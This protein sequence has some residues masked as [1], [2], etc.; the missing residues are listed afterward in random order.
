[1][2]KLY[3]FLLIMV[4]GSAL[5]QATAYPVDDL[6]SCSGVFD[7]EVQT[8]VTLANQ[9]PAE[10]SVSYFLSEPDA[11]ANVNPIAPGP[12]VSFESPQLIIIR[13]TNLFNDDYGLTAFH[14]YTSAPEVPQFP[15]M[16]ACGS[17]ALEWPGEGIQYFTLPGGQGMELFPGDVLT[18]PQTVYVF[19]EQDGCSSESS[20][21]VMT[22]PLPIIG[23]ITPLYSCVSPPLYNLEVVGQQIQGWNVEQVLITYHY[24]ASD[25]EWGVN[26][27]ESPMAYTALSQSEVIWVR[28]SIGG[29]TANICVSVV[30]VE[31]LSGGCEE[32]E[33]LITG[34]IHI[35]D[36][37]NGCNETSPGLSGAVVTAT[38]GNT[39]HYA[40]TNADGSYAFYGVEP[41]TAEVSINTSWLS[42]FIQPVGPGAQAVTVVAEQTAEA[43]FCVNFEEYHDVSISVYPGV[44]RPGLETYVTLFLTNEGSQSEN[45]VMTYAF[46]DTLLDFVSSSSGATV[47]GNIV[48]IPFTVASQQTIAVVLTFTVATPPVAD[49]GMVLN[50]TATAILD[51]DENQENNTAVASTTIV[52]SYDPND[53]TVHEGA[54]ISEAQAGDYLHYTVRFQNMGTAEALQVRIENELSAFLDWTTF[55]PIAAS[56][57]FFTERQNGTLTFRFP[58]INLAPESQDEAAS[59]GYVTYRVKPVTG[60]A[61]GDEILNQASIFFDF[62]SAIITNEVST[63]ISSMDVSEAETASVALYPNPASGQF[64]VKTDVPVKVSI[65]DLSGKVVL[66][67]RIDGAQTPVKVAHL[68][69]GMYLV[70]VEGDVSQ[71]V[72][73]LILK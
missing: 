6:F 45:A 27:I 42:P 24:T 17:Y 28:A 16:T 48:S 8:P 53:I 3:T 68:A 25:A 32:Y 23:N 47:S 70:K 62:N 54:F 18:E 2:K 59:Q 36:G 61:E 56:H 60:F 37:E 46:D 11:H 69:S 73:K 29:T 65:T 72:R 35:S 64:F 4:T 63:Q 31:L 20:F 58:D 34:T 26:P 1:M 10:F 22:I 30:P 41:G 15:D 67:Q 40:F 50:G 71:S 13:V 7:L 51:S 5:A 9:N 55:E 66:E 52:N 14:L 12:F 21:T 38:Q 49:L 33:P 44:A 57:T 39:V 43:D 19:A